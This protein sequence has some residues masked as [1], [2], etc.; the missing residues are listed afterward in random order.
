MDGWSNWKNK[1]VFIILKNNR[2]YSGEVIDVDCSSPPLI[3][4]TIID[5]YFKRVT[6]VHSEIQTIQEE[7]K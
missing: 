1:H 5:K 6:M 2:T 7:R 4:I 3:F